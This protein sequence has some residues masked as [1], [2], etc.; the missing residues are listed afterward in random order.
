MNPEETDLPARSM[1]LSAGILISD[2]MT[3]I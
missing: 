3:A 2:A 1:T